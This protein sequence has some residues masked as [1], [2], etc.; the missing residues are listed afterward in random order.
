VADVIVWVFMSLL[1]MS[2][3]DALL[4][5][6]DSLRRTEKRRSKSRR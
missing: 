4:K 1:F 6:V 5:T 3:L 2:R